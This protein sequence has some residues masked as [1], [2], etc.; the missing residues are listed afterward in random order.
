MAQKRCF[1]I[2]PIG[3]EG[4]KTREHADDVFEGIIKPAIEECGMEAYRS[5]QLN[6]P[7][8][9]TD[10]MFSAILHEDFCIALLTYLNPNV[11]YELAVAQSIG[12]PVIMLMEKGENLP[13]D[14]KDLRYIPYDLR[15]QSV[16]SG[17]YRI[18]LVKQIRDLE[19]RGWA[20]ESILHRYGVNIGKPIKNRSMRSIRNDQ[21]ICYFLRGIKETYFRRLTEMSRPAM[22]RARLNIMAPEEEREDTKL[23][24]RIITADYINDYQDLERREKW[25]EGQGKCGVAWQKSIQQVFASDINTEET[26]FEEM[27]MKSE[28][29]YEIKSVLSTPILLHE[30]PIAILNMDSFHGGKETLLHTDAVQAIFREGARAIVSLLIGT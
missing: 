20:A 24:L 10:Q 22:I 14:I 27:G 13:F 28:T 5:D 1:V 9:I 25:Y 15:P 18:E 12:K 8:R 11:F 21:R 2:S 4:S 16:R 30:Q 19:S 26:S 7:G 6:E 23:T 29:A 17:I 3:S